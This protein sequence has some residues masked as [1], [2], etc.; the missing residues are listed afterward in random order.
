M[1][2]TEAVW[3]QFAMPLFGGAVCTPPPWRNGGLGPLGGPEWCHKVAVGQPYLLLQTVF[4]YTV[5][6][7]QTT[8]RQTDRQTDGRTIRATV[9]S[10]KNT[11]S[12]TTSTQCIA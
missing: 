12:M 8:D 4:R 7:L 2:L 5:H 6:A 11:I 3:P 1:P 9:R 10:A